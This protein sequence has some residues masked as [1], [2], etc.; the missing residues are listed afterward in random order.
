M[1]V[2][3][4]Q[5]KLLEH[6]SDTYPKNV[7]LNGY[8]SFVEESLNKTEAIRE[9]PYR[10]ASSNEYTFV[11]SKETTQLW[12]SNHYIA[13]S[14]HVVQDGHSTALELHLKQKLTPNMRHVRKLHEASQVKS[15]MMETSLQPGRKP[16]NQP[17]I[18]ST[19]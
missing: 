10:S 15:A 1:L 4:F 13:Y 19:S 11:Y 6:S 14:E 2:S 7:R 12:H 16:N 8:W 3:P 18:W 5:S 9:E 17:H